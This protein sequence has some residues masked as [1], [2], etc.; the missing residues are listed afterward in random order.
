MISELTAAQ[1]CE[2]RWFV[3]HVSR[4]WRQAEKWLENPETGLEHYIPRQLRPVTINGRTRLQKV[5]AIPG[6]LFIHASQR[7]II[8]FKKLHN[9][10]TFVSWIAPDRPTRY[11]MVDDAQMADFIRVSS[12]G[13]LGLTYLAPDQYDLRAGQRV[14]IIGGPFDGVCGHF[15]RLKGKRN[16]RMLV[17]IDN[18][19]GI[20]IEISPA[21]LQL[22]PE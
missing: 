7:E 21:L 14:R 9:Q 19:Y 6:Y 4:V 22:L 20:S 16:R 13:Q 11:L 5:W 3:M 2:T 18:F 10:I 1:S 8:E 12:S 17:A 15:I